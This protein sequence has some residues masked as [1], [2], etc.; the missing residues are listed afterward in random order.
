MRNP[1][2]VL[3]LGLLGLAPLPAGATMLGDAAIPYR[4]ERTVTIDGRT[5]SGPVFHAPGHQRHEQDL[6]G[7]HEV[8]LLDIKEARGLL[9]L[10]GL[11]TY[12]EFPF[13][14]L[15][16]ELDSPDL[17]SHPVGKE[18][19]AGIATTKY[20]V[21]HA[22]KDGSRAK[23]FLWS[24][25]S[26]VLMKLDV[27]VTRAHGGKPMLIAMV[28]SQVVT[29]PVDPALFEPPQGFARLPPDA[30]GPLLGGK[31]G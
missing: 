21:D 3:A 16:A 19:V 18:E 20:R 25:A 12:V 29:G 8:F 2:L 23:G 5:Y 13:P 14:P 30:L 7:M 6:L 10:P 28:L 4:A 11:K 17:L 27:S 26:G 9:V 24:S 22:A 1:L 15:M 31:P